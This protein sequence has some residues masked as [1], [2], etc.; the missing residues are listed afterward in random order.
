MLRARAAAGAGAVAGVGGELPSGSDQSKSHMAPSCGTSCL[1]SI[2]RIWS[3]VLIDGESPP[4][5][6]NV[7][8][9]QEA[10]ASVR[11]CRAVP[12]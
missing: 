12:A 2:T 9:C 10:C 11:A 6:Q 5:T 4:C 1:R 7:R 8:S 3:S